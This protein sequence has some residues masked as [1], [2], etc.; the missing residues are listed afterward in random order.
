MTKKKENVS[1]DVYM[2]DS[3]YYTCW[4]GPITVNAETHPELE[5]MSEEEIKDYVSQNA[6]EMAS[7]SEYYDNLYDELTGM[8]YVKDK[9]TG[10]EYEIEF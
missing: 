2:R 4:R 3:H 7:T 10:E 6:S 8:D 5:G 1:V 9:I